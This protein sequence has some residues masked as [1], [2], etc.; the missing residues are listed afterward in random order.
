MFEKFLH[1]DSADFRQRYEG[2]YGF[3][4][5]RKNNKKLLVNIERVDT[6]DIPRKV[7]FRDKRGISFNIYSDVQDD[8]GFEFLPPKSAFYNTQSGVFYVE[9]RAARQFRRGICENNC[10]VYSLNDRGFRQSRVDFDSLSSIFE[11]P[12]PLDQ[13]VKDFQ[14]KKN[15]CIALT[16]FMAICNSKLYMYKEDIGTVKD[17]TITLKEGGMLFLTELQDAVK[18]L[19][20]NFT[21][22]PYKE[23]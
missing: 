15:P 22:V 6:E 2:T 18:T 12:I 1:D 19:N 7:I 21:I 4:F 3:F 14:N 16:S 11:M 5:D 9:R 20:L 13:A 8:I 23:A 17:N 10:L